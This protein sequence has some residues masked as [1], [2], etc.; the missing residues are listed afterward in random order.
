[1]LKKAEKKR[2][3]A[4]IAA[5]EKAAVA[6]VKVEGGKV[7]T[8]EKTVAKSVAGIQERQ[9][10]RKRIKKEIKTQVKANKAAKKAVEES[11][12]KGID[13]VR[14]ESQKEEAKVIQ[15]QIK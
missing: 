12:K 1:M 7:D 15:R 13:V 9:A 14:V 5:A 8:I 6:E 4:I 11:L 2:E 3:K 10:N